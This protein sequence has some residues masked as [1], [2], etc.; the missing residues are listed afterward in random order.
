[1]NLIANK[2]YNFSKRIVLLHKF[3]K[4]EK[5]E[6]VMSNQL[7]RSGTSIGSNITEAL[8]GQSKADFI[9]KMS[10]AL[11]ETAETEYWL[12]LLF[13]TGY[14]NKKESESITKDCLELKKILISIIKTSKNKQEFI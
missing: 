2:S 9:S 10:I 13:D 8:Q 4:E 7:L 14:L 1:M 11:K 6:F 3:L 5:K 12:N